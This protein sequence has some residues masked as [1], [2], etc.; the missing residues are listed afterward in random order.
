M[1]T[2]PIKTMTKLEKLRAME[3]LWTDLTFDE[4]GYETPDWHLAELE[5][6]EVEIS[7][8]RVSFLDWEEA[9]KSLRS[10]TQ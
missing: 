5:R 6:T 8:G 2:L 4:I 1:T 10:K 7:A 3:E 9:K